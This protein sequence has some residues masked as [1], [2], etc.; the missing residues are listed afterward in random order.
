MKQ[1]HNLKTFEQFEIE[2]KPDLAVEE[3]L[4]FSN[5]KD[6]VKN[7]GKKVGGFLS[8]WNSKEFISWAKKMGNSYVM[9]GRISKDLYEKA[10]KGAFN[11]EDENVEIF[12]KEMS[13]VKGALTQGRV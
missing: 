13:K 9:N 11:P 8:G 5:V 3:E 12:L 1:L 10:V 6:G 4:N 7:V 2:Y